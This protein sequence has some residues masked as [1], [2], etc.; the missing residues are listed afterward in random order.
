M[1][2]IQQLDLFAAANNYA[3]LVKEDI[4]KKYGPQGFS[5]IVSTLQQFIQALTDNNVMVLISTDYQ[6]EQ[7]ENIIKQ[8]VKE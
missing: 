2:T 8:Q 5:L 6:K 1:S 3:L 4:T 7:Q